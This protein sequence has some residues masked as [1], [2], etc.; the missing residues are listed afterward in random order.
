V[1][2]GS[3]RDLFD[4]LV[5]YIS[6]PQTTIILTEGENPYTFSALLAHT[7]S[8]EISSKN[9]TFSIDNPNIASVTVVS[10]PESSNTIILTPLSP[11]QAVLTVSNTEAGDAQK[12]L[13]VVNSANGGNKF[14]YLT[15]GENVIT[16][17]PGEYTAITSTLVNAAYAPGA[18]WSWVSQ[19]TGVAQI[20]ANNG[21][22]AMIQAVSPGTAYITVTN[23]NCRY[24][25]RFIVICLEAAT[26]ASRPWIKTSANIINLKGTDSATVTAE[27]IG[28]T[29]ADSSAFAWSA[30]SSTVALASAS[31]ASCYVKALLPGITYITVRNTNY[32]NGYPKTI[33]V[34]V[35]D[36]YQAECSITVSSSILKINPQD[37]RD[38]QITA[39][40]TNG[41]PT[42]PRDF[43]WWADD[44]RL[45]NLTSAANTASIMPLGTAGVT[46][47]HVK[48]PKAKNT[49]DILVF[50]SAYDTFRFSSNTK[51][52]YSASLAF[53]SLEVPPSQNP[54]WITY[55]TSNDR[56]CLI[57]GSSSAAMLSGVSDGNTTVYANLNTDNGVIASAE[58]S[59]IVYSKIVNTP[60]L[61][62]KS[63]I[64]T[65][66]KGKSVTLSAALSG[67][68]ILPAD[69]YQIQ[70]AVQNPAVAAVKPTVQNA[71]MGKDAYITAK[72]PGETAVSLTHPKCPVGIDILI[73]VPDETEL[74]PV[75]DRDTITLYKGDGSY[76]VNANII[77]GKAADYNNLFWTAP[78][79]G[80]QIIVTL[81]NNSGK[82]CNVIPRNTGTTVLRSQLPNG[83]SA[84]CV[85]TV[86]SETELVFETQSVHVNPG[87]SATVSYHSSPEN[88]S[89]N[90]T[91]AASGGDAASYF[92]Y[93]IDEAAKT[94]TITGL[95]LGSGQILGYFVTSQGGSTQRLNVIV[96]YDY[97]FSLLQG[98]IRTEPA[99]GKTVKINY[100]VFPNDLAVAA[101]S[102]DESA[103][104]VKSV[105]SSKDGYGTVELMPVKEAADLYV[106]LA[107]TNPDDKVNTPIIR[108]QYIDL[109][110]NDLTV[111]PH[112]DIVSGAFS[113]WN[114]ASNTLYL[115][116]GEDALFYLTIAQENAVIS[117]L[118]LAWSPAGAVTDYNKNY[119]ALTK[120]SAVTNTGIGL[121]RLKSTKDYI[122]EDV[123]F[124]IPKDMFY[125]VW[126]I[127]TDEYWYSVSPP[128]EYDSDFY[129]RYTFDP[130]TGTYGEWLTSSSATGN[131]A[132]GTTAGQGIYEWYAD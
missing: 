112:F 12:V 22:A 20:I 31:G 1:S 29:P 122:L 18:S 58:C 91:A 23:T 69:D 13:V 49:V 44:Y 56:V 100:R 87:Y 71:A 84:F 77:N 109:L 102:S 124:L 99:P 19:N 32:P 123:N 34:S 90:W 110:Y 68:G 113:R 81:S 128:E 53:I 94:I 54:Q 126:Q 62:S 40:L 129:S 33:L 82:T 101:S 107:A 14:P 35:E 78:K 2:V 98:R 63:T 41:S 43:L 85:I 125:E 127:D 64:V 60:S 103:L 47:V 59:V 106:T 93:T 25:L 4:S 70:W 75:L 16:I 72:N 132:I 7:E 51:T 73:S 105:S 130:D 42:D 67:T 111:V 6:V 97:E 55:S 46:T 50:L 116:D 28:G 9:F 65:L 10:N 57:T 38:T 89:I 108:T 8:G 95:R 48:H 74:R 114:E 3:F 30:A 76:A 121:W 117:N 24:P 36:S 104:I 61:S 52:L 26:A 39:S 120:E 17:L 131:A 79:S 80:G 96:E 88:I 119:I 86:L 118:T 83:K 27:M 37:T 92:S 66:E 21:D 115:G 15:T 45:I 11:G 5:P